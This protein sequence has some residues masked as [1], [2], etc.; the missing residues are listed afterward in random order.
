MRRKVL[1]ARILLGVIFLFFGLNEFLN[2][3]RVPESNGEGALAIIHSI[4][5]GNLYVSIFAFVEVVSGGLLLAGRYL[6]LAIACLFPVLV[7]IAVFHILRDQ[8]ALPFALL[9]WILLGFLLWS[10]REPFSRLTMMRTI[11]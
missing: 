11:P 2:F 10:H 4:T 5:T 8:I 1:I 6:P 7:K 9:D 3:I